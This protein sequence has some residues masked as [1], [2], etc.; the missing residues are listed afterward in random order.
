MNTC[1][2]VGSRKV[3]ILISHNYGRGVAEIVIRYYPHD[4]R[5][6][7]Q[8]STEGIPR[9]ESKD[10]NTIQYKIKSFKMLRSDESIR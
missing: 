8:T 5:R 1:S 7:D 9:K 3:E 6:R 4:S 10:Y 2:I